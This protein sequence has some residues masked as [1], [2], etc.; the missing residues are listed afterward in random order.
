MRQATQKSAVALTGFGMDEDIS[1]CTEA[2]FNEH[3]TKPV[4][5]QRLEMLIRRFA[6]GD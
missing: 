5:F 3:L 6:S 2:G 4:S 1:K